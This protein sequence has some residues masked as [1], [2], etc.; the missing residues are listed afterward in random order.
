ATVAPADLPG[1]AFAAAVTGSANLVAGVLCRDTGELYEFLTD[2]LGSL[3]AIQR[4]ELSPVT[5]TVK[6]AGLLTDGH[7]LV[8]PAH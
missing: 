8:D 5:R 2:R 1:I 4:A 3:P 7:R 6:R